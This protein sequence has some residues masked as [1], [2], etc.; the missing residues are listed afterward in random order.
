MPTRKISDLPIAKPCR[1]PDHRPA[2][3]VVRPPGIYEHTCPSCGQ[4][5]T[6]VVP[7]GPRWHVGSIPVKSRRREAAAPTI[8]TPTGG[9][10]LVDDPDLASWAC[11]ILNAG[12]I[13]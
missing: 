9:Q 13:K 3:M 12:E 2:T 10:W 4:S 1:D 7:P 5:F 11:D 6:F 8:E